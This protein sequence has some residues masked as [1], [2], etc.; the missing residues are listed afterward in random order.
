MNRY[1]VIANV[2]FDKI[3]E[4]TNVY[5]EFT[6]KELPTKDEILKALQARITLSTEIQVAGFEVYVLYHKIN[7][8]LEVLNNG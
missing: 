7:F 3:S 6:K 8:N 1:V 2:K 4:W 5:L